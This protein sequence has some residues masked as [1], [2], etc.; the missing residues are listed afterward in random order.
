MNGGKFLIYIDILGFE[1][2][3]RQLASSIN[4]SGNL[5][6]ENWI[7]ENAFLLP[8]RSSI[9]KIEKTGIKIQKLD[10]TMEGSDTFLLIIDDLETI[11]RILSTVIKIELPSFGNEDYPYIPVEI[12]IDFIKYDEKIKNPI[13]SKEIISSIKTD[14][15]KKYRSWYKEQNSESIKKTYILLTGSVFDKLNNFQQKKC[16]SYIISKTPVYYLPLDVVDREEKINSFFRYINQPKS[17]YCGNLIDEIYI[18]PDEFD[19]IVNKLTTDRFVFITGPPGY[20]KT[21]TAIRLLWN[22]FLKGITPIW[23]DGAEFQH[24]ERARQILANIDSKLQSKYIFYFEDPFGKIEYENRDDLIQKCDFIFN[25]IKNKEQV[26][27]VITS[28]KDI[29]EE[30][31]RRCFSHSQIKSLEK[32]LNIV[33]PSYG[34]YKRTKILRIWAEEK[35]CKWITNRDII[36]LI[37]NSIWDISLL[38]TPL[39]IHDFIIATQNIDDELTINKEIERFSNATEKIFADEIIGL[40]ESKRYDRILLLS[41]IFISKDMT[42]SLS[43]PIVLKNLRPVYERLRRESFKDIDTLIMEEHRIEIRSYY[44]KFSHPLYYNAFLYLL[45]HPGIKHIIIEVINDCVRNSYLMEGIEHILIKYYN[46]FPPNIQN[47]LFKLI[48]DEISYYNLF[49]DLR[50]YNSALPLKVFN[51]LIILA[52]KKDTATNSGFKFIEENY[53]SLDQKI[54]FELLV[55]LSKYADENSTLATILERD[56]D[57]LPVHVRN[58]LLIN[59]VNFPVSSKSIEKV[60]KKKYSQISVK[61]RNE[62]LYRWS[63]VGSKSYYASAF[64]NDHY[65]EISKKFRM[66]LLLRLSYSWWGPDCI[67]NLFFKIYLELPESLKENLLINLS[68]SCY[69][70][71]IVKKI[72]LQNF[73]TV[74]ESSLYRILKVLSRADDTAKNAAIIIYKKF[75]MI[76]PNLRNYLIYPLSKFNSSSRILVWVILKHYDKLPEN[77]RNLLFIMSENE[78]NIDDIAFAISEY[79]DKL[80]DEIQSL[81]AFIAKK[82]GNRE[83][84]EEREIIEISSKVIPPIDVWCDY[85][86][87]LCPYE[88]N[89]MC[90]Y[91]IKNECPYFRHDNHFIND[92]PFYDTENCYISDI[93]YNFSK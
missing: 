51:K 40:Y 71:K 67:A 41:L 69:S 65:F 57:L 77:I 34:Y 7:R 9:E 6:S 49:N 54:K 87:G 75:D 36:H 68:Y 19:E 90:G 17:D 93:D 5:S 1:N 12:G 76:N 22:W 66:K 31:E 25:S 3:P 29:F 30:F 58:L 83:I 78:N 70:S 21:Y 42:R 59:L 11:F 39:S 35:K 86:N 61:T 74:S 24:R 13:A 38:P 16:S 44:I 85:F 55:N 92:C 84:Y 73:S 26:F 53:N 91:V 2:L 50:I 10:Q 14:L 33:H 63:E 46:K 18:E 28:R 79:Y 15:F 81:L 80:P 48:E 8:F 32:E 56:F 60:L 27:V 45:D 89:C 64:L 62:I 37:C 4:N 20:G 72:I 52:S 88:N 82:Y 43:N 47:L 23:V